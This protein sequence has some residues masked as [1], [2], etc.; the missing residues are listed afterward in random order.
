[1][2]DVYWTH[3]LGLQTIGSEQICSV[4]LLFAEGVLYYLDLWKRKLKDNNQE[5]EI[6]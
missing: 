3:D 1:M 4:K 5:I 6:M 2:L